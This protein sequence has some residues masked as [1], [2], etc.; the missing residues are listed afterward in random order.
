MSNIEISKRCFHRGKQL[1][2]ARNITS[3]PAVRITVKSAQ[4]K[5]NRGLG[6][7]EW[8]GSV[9]PQGL[10]VKSVKY[11]W[12]TAWKRLMTELAPQSKE[13]KFKRPGYQY[14]HVIG[15][16]EFPLQDGRYHVYVGNPC[17]WC[18]RI[19]LGLALRGLATADGGGAISFTKL[20]A[21]PERASR[22][23]WV[24][25]CKDPVFGAKDL[26]EVYDASS[27]TG[28]FTGRC[29]A[30]LLV[31]KVTKRAVCNESSII[32]RN[33]EKL[34]PGDLQ[35]INSLNVYP[36]EMAGCIEKWNEKIYAAVNDG[37]YK[38]GFATTQNAYEEAMFALWAT[39]DELETLLGKQRFICGDK[40]TEADIRLFPT[41]VR[42]DAAYAVLFKTGRF[43]IISERPNLS[44]WMRDIHQINVG[45]N[46]LQIS[47]CVDIDD[48]RTSYFES[49]FPLNPG[50][51]VPVGPCASDLNLMA[52][53]HR[54]SSNIQEIFE[55]Y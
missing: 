17:P 42:F 55:M 1:R 32:L 26:R 31:D 22:G 36:S 2:P 9:V 7:L 15:D 5:P 29:T 24:F 53:H 8:T 6:V 34:R 54:G 49:L 35:G 48:A 19:L 25:D 4:E 20:T 40:L 52:E 47:D 44:A 39:L 37:V 12:R 13:G 33:I 11:S 23:G 3:R 43:K 51:L 28:R 46:G 50:L 41:I 21:S 38:C 27:P 16:N 14:E 18:H 10:L 30:P 45:G